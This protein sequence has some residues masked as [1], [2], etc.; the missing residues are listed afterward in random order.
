M[1]GRIHWDEQLGF[2]FAPARVEAVFPNAFRVAQYPD[3]SRRVQGAYSWSQ[4][5]EG[6]VIWR[7]LPLVQVD[8]DGQEIP[9]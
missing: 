3:G 5:S 4:G 9:A 6:G 1:M 7:D 2:D 8:E